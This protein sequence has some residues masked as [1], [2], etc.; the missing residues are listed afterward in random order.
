MTKLI[1]SRLKNFKC[2]KCNSYLKRDQLTNGYNCSNC[3]FFVGRERFD[4]LV[5]SLHKK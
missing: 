4:N 1:W 2:P 5:N 3:D